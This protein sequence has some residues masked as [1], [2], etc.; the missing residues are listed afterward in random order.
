MIYII[1]LSNPLFQYQ[2]LAYIGCNISSVGYFI[3]P[4]QNISIRLFHIYQPT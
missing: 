4:R 1:L 2:A 3:D